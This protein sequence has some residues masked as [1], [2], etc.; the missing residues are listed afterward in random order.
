[1]MNTDHMMTT[2]DNK[3]WPHDDLHNRNVFI[4]IG[5]VPN[6]SCHMCS[7]H[8]SQLSTQKTQKKRTDLTN[9]KSTSSNKYKIQQYQ[10]QTQ[11]ES[12][13]PPHAQLW[14]TDTM[15]EAIGGDAFPFGAS[16]FPL[17]ITFGNFRQINFD[18]FETNTF[19]NLSQI[20]FAWS[21]RRRCL[22]LWCKR[23]SQISLRIWK[24]LANI[25]KYPHKYVAKHEYVAKQ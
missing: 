19:F 1:M 25:C 18:I 15:R 6:R 10:Q 16:N 3:N 23:L 13:P 17:S 14:P 8:L 4:R 24:Y 11:T 2:K 20:Y 21:N 9:T 5:D 22:S 7:P 12:P